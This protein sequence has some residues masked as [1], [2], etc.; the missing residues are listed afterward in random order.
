MNWQELYNSVVSGVKLTTEQKAEIQAEAEKRGVHINKRCSSCYRDALIQFI[1]Q[2]RKAEQ[3]AEV[4]KPRLKHFAV[5]PGL[6][7]VFRGVRVNEATLD[8]RFS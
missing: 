7:V 4:E 8:V 6:D 3:G 2:D 5:R 1:A